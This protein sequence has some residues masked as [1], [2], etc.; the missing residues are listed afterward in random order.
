MK[1]LGTN[2]SLK[3]TFA[4]I[5]EAKRT[6]KL[7]LLDGE[8][9]RGRVI[10]GPTDDYVVIQADPSFSVFDILD[11][12][13]AVPQKGAQPTGPVLVRYAAIATVEVDPQ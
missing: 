9:V 4:A 13:P 7:K 1:T 2:G 6:A 5:L 10:G 8:F 3:G 12:S 11:D